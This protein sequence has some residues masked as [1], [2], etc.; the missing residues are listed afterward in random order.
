MKKILLSISL[1]FLSFCAYSTV[2]TAINNG[3]YNDPNTWQDMILPA[4][5]YGDTV[6]INA[7]ITV[8]FNSIWYGYGDLINNG[9][10]NIDWRFDN[11]AELT[12]YGVININM[13]DGQLINF[14]SV[15]NVIPGV[16]NNLNTMIYSCGPIE[17]SQ[18]MLIPFGTSCYDNN[19]LT[20]RDKVVEGC[21]CEGT[22]N[23][24]ADIEVN[25]LHFTGQQ[26]STT[27]ELCGGP[28]SA[29][30]MVTSGPPNEACGP[31]NIDLTGKIA[32]IDRAMCS[33][34]DKFQNAVDSGAIAVIICNHNPGGGIS[35]FTTLEY[36]D[37]PGVMMSY[38]DCLVLKMNIGSSDVTMTAANNVYYKDGDMDGYGNPD[39]TIMSCA[40][41][42]GYV[43]N[44]DDCNDF[45]I[46]VNPTTV[47]YKDGDM[48]GYGN[49]DSTLISCLQPL[50]Y[51]SNGE[52]CDDS[53]QNITAIGQPCDD[54]NSRTSGDFMDL[55]CNCVFAAVI[56]TLSQW[57]LMILSL[58]FMIVGVIYVKEREVLKV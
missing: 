9:T 11:Y 39:S 49:I 16:I 18:T 35:G 12:N 26:A 33:F 15:I 22:I 36:F 41:P 48:D 47:Y 20:S 14:G 17:G 55:N 56:P 42:E 4:D 2:F 1:L 34:A 10:I 21:K 40:Q 24:Y 29:P 50:G 23:P 43:S 45:D 44:L 27:A 6:I 53:L 30:A 54:G 32:V 57:G 25:G 28:I 31:L 58:C 51:V 8:D 13:S 7:G 37:I 46:A 38:E 3:N 52:D 5:T 19:S